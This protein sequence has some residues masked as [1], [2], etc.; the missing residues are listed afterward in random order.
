[1]RVHYDLDLLP[2]FTNAVITIGSFD[3]VHLGHQQ[4]LKKINRLARRIGGESVVITFHPHPRSIIYPQDDSL[5][6]LSTI[7]EKVDLFARYGVDHLVV[8]PFS[9]AFS[10]LSADEYIHKFLVERF[11]PR[12][13]VIGYDHR[14]GLN[15]LGDVNY[16]K[17]HGQALGYE[18]V[19]IEKQELDDISIS[20]TKIRYALERG[21]VKTANRLLGHSYALRGKVVHGQQIGAQLG[22]PT[23]NIDPAFRYKL[24]PCDGIYAVR[25]RHEEVWYDGMLYIGNR[26]TLKGPEHRTIEVNIFDFDQRIYGHELEVYVLDFIRADANFSDMDALREQLARDRTDAQAR[27]SLL[28][29]PKDETG[30]ADKTAVVI[31]NYNGRSYLEAFL[32]AV[33][34]HTPPE[35]DIYVADNASTD[36]SLSWLAAHHPKVRVL[37][38]PLNYG[39]A[40]GY[41]QALRQVEADV[42]VLLNSDV[43]VGPGWLDGCLNQ[44]Q[45]NRKMAACQPKI[46]AYHHRDAFEYAGAAGGWLDALG[47]PFCR[48]RIFGHTETDRGQYDEPVE[49]FWASGAALFIRADLFHRLGGFDGD[50][51]AH[52]EEIDLCWRLKRAGY[53]IGCDPSSVV[54]HVGGGTLS[55][56][57][58]RKTYL[59]FRNTLCTSF[60]N[61]PAGRLIWWFPVRLFMDALAGVLF[62]FQGKWDHIIAIVQAH[63]YFFPRMAYWWRK[64]KQYDALVASAR[65][66][67]DRC[68]EARLKGSV[69]WQ[70]YALRRRHFLDLK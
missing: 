45:Q 33:A 25:V 52:A 37:S 67:A 20:S 10:Q 57:T 23:A 27:L 17:W 5:R 29:H 31:L 35:V 44:L 49:I 2:G 46:R 22:F 4:L 40:E 58:P 50:Y 1:M 21:D 19:Q 43:E 54:Y 51:F 9:V 7:E 3:G 55:Y 48:G 30:G 59:N 39:F 42:Y 60:K 16:L 53:Q 12:Y 11:H 13:I 6:L 41:N 47:Y 8:A 63:W 56:Q 62:L 64:R 18:V 61:E 68:D 70:Y 32:P 14:F 15:R 26:P 34:T 69:V 24:I 28:P 65:I 38:L 36:D 66:G